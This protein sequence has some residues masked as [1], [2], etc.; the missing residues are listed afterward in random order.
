MQ[1]EGFLKS[2]WIIGEGGY[3]NIEKRHMLAAKSD[4]I[5]VKGFIRNNVWFHIKFK[6]RL[7]FHGRAT[8]Y[9]YKSIQRDMLKIDSIEKL[10]IREL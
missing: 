8:W 4:D 3:K 2:N 1:L 5:R 9:G 7:L 10:L 6:G